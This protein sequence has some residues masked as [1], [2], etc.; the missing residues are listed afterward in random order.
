MFLTDPGIK[1]F[2]VQFEGEGIDV[3]MNQFSLVRDLTIRK[4]HDGQLMLHIGEKYA[5]RMF[6][7][8]AQYDN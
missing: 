6:G 5:G 1:E 3:D 4:S 8:S 7:D 2:R